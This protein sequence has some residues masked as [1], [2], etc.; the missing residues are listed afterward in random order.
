MTTP[1]SQ[2]FCSGH[3][4]CS[5]MRTSSSTTT[6]AYGIM[7]HGRQ[8]VTSPPRSSRRQTQQ[9]TY[10]R[11]MFTAVVL[12]CLT[13]GFSGE[14]SAEHWGRSAAAPSS[15]SLAS[16]A[17]A[18]AAL[19]SGPVSSLFDED[20]STDLRLE[21]VPVSNQ[22]WRCYWYQSTILLAICCKTGLLNLFSLNVRFETFSLF[23]GNLC[24]R[25]SNPASI[26]FD[27]KHPIARPWNKSRRIKCTR[28]V[29][30]CS[31]YLDDNCCLQR[32]LVPHETAANQRPKIINA[33]KMTGILI[34]MRIYICCLVIDWNYCE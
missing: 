15:P 17:T 14:A 11:A 6:S 12:A 13:F 20:S 21:K 33:S 1:T 16:S 23:G 18:V 25:C 10:R 9:P 5:W 22:L 26:T 30:F 19:P 2:K 3:R 24:P 8:S 7:I 27:R 4:C 29:G 28:A 31:W 32:L 34:K